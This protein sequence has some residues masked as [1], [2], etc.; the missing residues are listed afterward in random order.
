MARIFCPLY[1]TV[2]VNW[3]GPI[4]PTLGIVPMPD[5]LGPPGAFGG[6]GYNRQDQPLRL[7]KPPAAPLQLL[8]GTFLKLFEPRQADRLHNA[9]ELLDAGAQPG[10][11]VFV[12]AEIF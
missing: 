8:G 10:Q 12:D 5:N 7:M 11:L 3:K 6:Q 1:D 2:I 9:A 4:H